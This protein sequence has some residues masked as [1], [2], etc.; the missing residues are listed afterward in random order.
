MNHTA[1][2]AAAPRRPLDSIVT[3]G[4]MIKFEHTIFALPFALAAAAIAA[5]GHGLSVVRVAGIVVAMAAAR[6]AAM[7]FNRIADRHI[8]AKNPRTARRE[9]PAGAVTLRAAWTLT[10]ASAAAFV[11][12]AALLGPL[13]LALSP[14]ALALLF[15][16]SFT[17]RFTFLCHLFLGLAIAAGPAGAWIAVR[18]DFTA[19]PGLLMLAVA[20]W[21]AGFDVLYALADRDF[22]RGAGL[23]S[24]PA[25]FGV[26]GS[27]LISGALHVV[28]LVAL[29]ALAPIAHLGAPYLAGVGVVALLLVYEHAIVRP[30]DL[31]RLDAA[32]FTLNG[33]VSVVFFVATLI[34][35]LAR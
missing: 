26:G 17:K 20:S 27:L 13:C 1:T 23:H 25:R 6:T 28:T 16:Y 5:R 30:S 2:E 4:R 11:V 34:D 35:V 32:F 21:I 33:Y 22:D 8:D 24:I 3:F 18:G 31:G 12:A 29:F 9:L 10:L 7:G 14:V 15:G 19:A